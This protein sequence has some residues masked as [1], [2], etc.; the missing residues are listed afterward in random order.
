MW[1]LINI[2][3]GQYVERIAYDVILTKNKNKALLIPDE[4][5]KHFKALAKMSGG[6]LDDVF[7]CAPF[8]ILSVQWKMHL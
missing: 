2:E 3:T 4:K 7:G 1:R 8:K 5:I 6:T